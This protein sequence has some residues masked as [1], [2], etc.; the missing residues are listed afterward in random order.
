M[1]DITTLRHIPSNSAMSGKIEMPAVG[2]KLPKQSGPLAKTGIE[3]GTVT[4]LAQALIV[5]TEGGQG[6]KHCKQ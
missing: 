2:L 1:T 3:H 4:E 6:N 5:I